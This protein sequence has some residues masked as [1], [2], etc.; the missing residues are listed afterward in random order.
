M[1]N[2]IGSAKVGVNKIT[3]QI[4]T[5]LNQGMQSAEALANDTKNQASTL[6]N[7]TKTQAEALAND[8]KNQAS[9]LLNQTKSQSEGLLNQT[10]TQAQE[11]ANTTATQAKSAL[12]EGTQSAQK[13]ASST[14]NDL[15]NTGNEAKN[16]LTTGAEKV[17]S[18]FEKTSLSDLPE[19]IGV[20]SLPIVGEALG[21]AGLVGGAIEG[22]KDMFSKGGPAPVVALP[23][24]AGIVHQA[25][26]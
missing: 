18:V 13:L 8:T 19:L 23:V 17:A 5:Q 12:T 15:T 11:L 6:L 4:N 7:Q 22:V 3:G 21:L 1:P 10:T 24:Q 25:G 9:T 20:S 2:V 16:L 26:I 14:I